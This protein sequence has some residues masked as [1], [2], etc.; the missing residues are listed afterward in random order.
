VHNLQYELGVESFKK[1]INQ[2]SDL[3][4]AEWKNKQR[5]SLAPEFSKIQFS[6]ETSKNDQDNTKCQD[7]WEKFLVRYGMQ[8]IAIKNIIL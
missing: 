8:F 6:T 1:G 4:I 7:A 3:T 2:W 5:P